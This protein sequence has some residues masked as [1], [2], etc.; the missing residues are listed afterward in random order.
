[1]FFSKDK[2]VA[3]FLS[4]EWLKLDLTS[5]KIVFPVKIWETLLEVLQSVSAKFFEVNPSL[6]THITT[7]TMP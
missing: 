7:I 3:K 6:P 5:E 1:M 2:A 4:G